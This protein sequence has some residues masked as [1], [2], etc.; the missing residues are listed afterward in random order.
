MNREFGALCCFG[1]L[2]GATSATMAQGEA[3]QGV[4][5]PG[6]RHVCV[7]AASGEGWDCGTDDKPPENYREPTPEAAPVATTEVVAEPA[8][9]PTTV[10]DTSTPSP[11]PFL[12]D[13]TRDTPYAPVE[14]AETAAVAESTDAPSATPSEAQ[15]VPAAASAPT[16]VAEP[17]VAPVLA[18]S[19]PAAAPAQPDPAPASE[20]EPALPEV[21]Q[22]EPVATPAA[23]VAVV[24]NGP[25]GGESDF[26]Q[27]PATSFTL[28][29]AYAGDAS[30]FARLVA[31]L[32][33]D[34]AT[35]YALQVRGPAGRTWL[36]AHGAFADAPTARAVQ[37]TL[38]R[39]A[40]L[41]AQWPRRIGALQTELA[42]QGR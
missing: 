35:C 14:T 34:P 31:E 28:Q 6:V 18:E 39:I 12:A 15:S 10:E 1:L 36:L 40:G 38:P 8:A 20:P 33:L 25:L 16:P 29:L 13:P 3:D 19:A 41:S 11:P 21:S 7:P 9:E 22:P 17:E 27:L 32:G 4:F 23:P 24:S 5:E 30:T 37:G 2:L 42:E 26:M